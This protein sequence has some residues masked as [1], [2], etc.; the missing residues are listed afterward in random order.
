MLFPISWSL[1][2]TEEEYDDHSN[3]PV[4]CP[5]LVEASGWIN[6]MKN[7]VYSLHEMLW[8]H[9]SQFLGGGD[10]TKLVCKIPVAIAG[11]SE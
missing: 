11:S 2:D 9:H 7:I 4:N 10:K 6:P 3:F 5:P 8:G 1:N